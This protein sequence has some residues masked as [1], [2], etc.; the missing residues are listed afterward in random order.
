M[1]LSVKKKVK[2]PTLED[3]NMLNRG[4]EDELYIDD[5]QQELAVAKSE[6][7]SII[8]DANK[9]ADAIV[10]QAIE[11]AAILRKE[12]MDEGV[13]RGNELA[14]T[15]QREMRS[16]MKKQF[17]TQMN[18]LVYDM[19]EMFNEFKTNLVNTVCFVAKKVIYKEFEEND[20]VINTLI[21]THLQEIKDRTQIKVHVSKDDYDKLNLSLFDN[22]EHSI[23]VEDRYKSGEMSITCDCEEIN[24][25]I[26]SQLGKIE[27]AIKG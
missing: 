24:F 16:G 27:S 6:A 7:L 9:S 12:K 23:V 8:A 19:E 10:S 15:I 11:K 17:E 25:S 3:M 20:E 21:N 22:V 5:P 1:N 4:E 13:Q 26:D 2:L 14:E 18:T